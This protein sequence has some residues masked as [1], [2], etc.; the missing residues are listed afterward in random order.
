MQSVFSII[1]RLGLQNQYSV[2]CQSWRSNLV[3]ANE[4]FFSFYYYAL[5]AP[6]LLFVVGCGAKFKMAAVKYVIVSS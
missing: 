6:L 1:S 3:L 5:L 4:V 2:I